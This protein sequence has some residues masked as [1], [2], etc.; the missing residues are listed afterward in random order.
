[1]ESENS[2]RADERAKTGLSDSRKDK[3]AHVS[4]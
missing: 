4:P 2:S 1:M 3:S